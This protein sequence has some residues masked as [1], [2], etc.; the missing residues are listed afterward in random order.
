VGDGSS[1]KREMGG[2]GGSVSLQR[3]DKC[4]VV[5]VGQEEEGVNPLRPVLAAVA[6][7]LQATPWRL[8][9]YNG[10]IVRQP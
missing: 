7:T 8:T 3:Q 4:L 2:A 1:H 6:R 5:R 10:V 9:Y